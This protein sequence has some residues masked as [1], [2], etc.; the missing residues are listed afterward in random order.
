MARYRRAIAWLLGIVVAELAVM[1]Y[2]ALQA[3]ENGLDVEISQEELI[4]AG[5][6]AELDMK[7]EFNE[8]LAE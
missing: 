2:V 5:E 6:Q 3:V 8:G 1:D 7:N 4:E